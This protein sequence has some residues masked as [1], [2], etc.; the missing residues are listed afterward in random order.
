MFIVI[1]FRDKSSNVDM[2][3]VRTRG[4]K[5]FYVHATLNKGIVEMKQIVHNGGLHTAR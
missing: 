5:L 4:N 3:R 2:L 1:C